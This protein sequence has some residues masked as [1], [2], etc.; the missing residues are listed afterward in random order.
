MVMELLIIALDR[1]MI[2]YFMANEIC[3]ALVF[4]FCDLDYYASCVL[5]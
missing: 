5:G 1:H 2:P 4:H 3:Y